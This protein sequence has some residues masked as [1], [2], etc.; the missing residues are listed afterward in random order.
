MARIL[1]TGGAG[2]IGSHIAEALVK[3]GNEVTILDDLSTGSEK[4]LNGFKSKVKFVKGSITD[5]NLLAELTNNTDVIFHEAAQISVVESIKHPGKTWEINIRGTKLLLNA[6]VNA[7]VKR[8]IFASSAAVYGRAQP[9]LHEGIVSK[10]TSNYGDSKRMGEMLMREYYEKEKLETVSLRYFNVYGPRQN[11]ASPYSG[12]ISIFAKALAEGKNPT[13]FGNGMQTRDFVY[14]DDVVKANIL[15]MKSKKAVGNVF[16]VGTGKQVTVLDLLGIMK[17]KMKTEVE[18]EFSQTR[19]GDIMYSYADMKKS[20]E[21]LGF[22][23]ET[24][25]E[26]GLERTLE[27]IKKWQDSLEQTG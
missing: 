19:P 15:A 5:R 23:A 2:F 6:A 11:P 1:V 4:N 25:L 3:D 10:P 8:V 24:D 22:E 18:A 13:I 9:P 26:N 17:K 7:K 12:V 27:W 14:I 20:K 21:T 16:N